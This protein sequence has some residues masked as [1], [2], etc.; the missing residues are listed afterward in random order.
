MYFFAKEVKAA[1]DITKA[2]DA[3]PAGYQVV[4]SEATGLPLLKKA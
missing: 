3:V 2:L 4:E 1:D